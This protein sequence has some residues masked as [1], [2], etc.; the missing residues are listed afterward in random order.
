M[1]RS[2]FSSA[3]TNNALAIFTTQLRRN[4]LTNCRK[5]MVLRTELRISRQQFRIAI[6]ELVA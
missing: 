3:A 2:L 6:K 1:K 4:C 5:L